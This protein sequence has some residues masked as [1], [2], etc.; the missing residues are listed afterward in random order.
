MWEEGAYE[1]LLVL[2]DEGVTRIESKKGH[3]LNDY[4]IGAEKKFKCLLHPTSDLETD[5]IHSSTLCDGFLRIGNLEALGLAEQGLT[6]NVLVQI[7]AETVAEQLFIFHLKY[8]L[9]V[10]PAQ[11][12]SLLLDRAAS[13]RFRSP[14]VFSQQSPHFLTRLVYTHILGL[15]SPEASYDVSLRTSFLTRW[16]EIGQSMKVQGDLAGFLAIATAL[17]SIPILRLKETW[18]DVDV[19]VRNMVIRD[20]SP[21]MKELHRRDLGGESGSWI[22]HVLTPDLKREDLDSHLVIPYYG[23]ICTALEGFEIWAVVVA[24]VYAYNRLLL[25][26]MSISLK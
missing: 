11:D 13:Q 3:A 6:G 1:S 4:V 9:A 18:T 25:I 16:I 24:K 14:L 23:D 5:S 12:M 26:W 22:A 17:L 10:D 19:E 7:P 8:L 20:W 15:D 2:V 21:M